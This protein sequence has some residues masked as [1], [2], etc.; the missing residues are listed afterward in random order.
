MM[1]TQMIFAWVERWLGQRRTREIFAVLFFLAMISLQLVGPML[2]RYGDRSSAAFHWAGRFANPV[3]AVL[4]P[5]IAAGALASEAFRTWHWP[6]CLLGALVLY[7]VV[8]LRIL[9]VR[10]RAQFRG[11]NLSEVVG[12]GK[13]QVSARVFAL[14][15]NVPVLS[16]EAAAVVEKEFRYLSRSGP[17]LLTFVTPIVMLFVFGLG[18]RSGSGA[19][20]LQNWP[21][22]ALPVGQP[23]RCC[24]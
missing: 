14:A 24:C 16:Q 8:F 7:A 4:P 17:V 20:F 21:D 12:R 9:S 18:G 2:S 3:Q 6:L 10:L 15:W 5:G 13:D 19:G 22:L 11:E 23:T 1:L